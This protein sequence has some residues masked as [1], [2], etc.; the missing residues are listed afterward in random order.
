MTPRWPLMIRPLA[1]HIGT[2]ACP[3]VVCCLCID[4]PLSRWCGSWCDSGV[5]PGALVVCRVV[6]VWC[7]CGALPGVIVM[8]V[9]CCR[10]ALQLSAFRA[11]VCQWWRSG[12]SHEMM[13]PCR[14]KLRADRTSGLRT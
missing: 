4:G 12:V 11:S 8:C 2:A 13:G 5:G 10:G 6:C 14:R 3:L 1:A 9:W 7:A